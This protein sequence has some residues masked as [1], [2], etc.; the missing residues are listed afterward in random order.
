MT[1]ARRVK[2]QVDALK[3]GARRAGVMFDVCRLMI[4]PPIVSKTP[5][6]LITSERPNATVVGTRGTWPRIAPRRRTCA[7][8]AS[9]PGTWL[10]IAQSRS[11]TVKASVTHGTGFVL[12]AVMQ[13]GGKAPTKIRRSPEPPMRSAHSAR[14]WNM[15]GVSAP[16]ER[17]TVSPA[18]MPTSRRSTTT[19]LVR[20]PWTRRAG[21]EGGHRPTPLW[22]VTLSR[23]GCRTLGPSTSADGLEK[24]RS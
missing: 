24:S 18:S 8:I 23:G 5:G 4:T 9:D 3:N 12:Q 7:T 11:E 22:A 17:S 19:L 21:S 6:R 1:N 15:G 16:S 14:A 20:S 13:N 10:R 2:R